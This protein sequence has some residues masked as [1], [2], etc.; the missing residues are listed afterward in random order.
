MPGRGLN[1]S[2]LFAGGRIRQLAAMRETT[3][4]A[5][6]S[7]RVFAH[8]VAEKAAGY[9][10]VLAEF[11]QARERFTIHLRPGEVARQTGGTDEETEGLL[12]QLVDWGNLERSPDT[13]EAA[14]I[15]EFHRARFLY[16]LSAAGEAAEEALLRFHEILGRPGELQTMALRDITRFLDALRQLLLEN[17]PDVAKLHAQLRELNSTFRELTTQAQAFIRGLHGTVELH[18]IGAAEFQEYKTAL[19]GY[20]ER[21]IGELV[22]ATNEIAGKIEEVE[23][24]GIAAR[25]SDVAERDLSDRLERTPEDDRETLARWEGRWQGLRRWFIGA[26]GPSQAEILRARAREAVP[27]LLF[28]LQNLNDRRL[29]KSD[30]VA[31]WQTLALWFAEAPEEDD[32]HRLWRTAFGLA[33]AR[34]LRV[35]RETLDQREQEPVGPRVSW[36]DAEPLWITPRLRATGQAAAKGQAKSVRDRSQQKAE[37]AKMAAEQAGQIEAARRLLARGERMRL[38]EFEELDAAAFELL[39]DLLGEALGAENGEAFSTDG[40]L[41]ISL[42]ISPEL[43]GRAELRTPSGILC[44]RDRWVTIRPTHQTIPA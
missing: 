44:G 10:A 41:A 30:R 3:A 24:A 19:I 31:D 34:H 23:A 7:H 8:L 1:V 27:A 21:F 43:A 17:D 32:C 35:N 26:G 39:L 15:E 18:G 16:Q 42:E 6:R 22:L 20:I 37:L 12:A 14:T 2:F 29:S 5:D 38:S 33:P 4:G 40:A 36:L 13:A 25:L 11:S 9:R 28:T